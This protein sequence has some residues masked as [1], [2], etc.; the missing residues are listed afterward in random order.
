MCLKKMCICMCV[1][2][3]CLNMYKYIISFRLNGPISKLNEQLFDSDI[4]RVIFTLHD[5]ERK[6]LICQSILCH[7]LSI[8]A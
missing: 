2:M 1:C 8:M 4:K 7:P 5:I 3:H 6:V